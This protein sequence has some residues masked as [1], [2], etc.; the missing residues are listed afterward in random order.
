MTCFL[1]IYTISDCITPSSPLLII[2]SSDKISSAT[3]MGGNRFQLVEHISW[4]A[5]M[6]ARCRWIVKIF[7]AP[8]VEL[9]NCLPLIR[10]PGGDG[11]PVM[12]HPSRLHVKTNK[13][14]KHK[15]QLCLL[16][17]S[18]LNKVKDTWTIH[19]SVRL[20]YRSNSDT[21]TSKL[22]DMGNQLIRDFKVMIWTCDSI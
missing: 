10:I 4:K 11:N 21:E 12:I 7:N 5:A 8:Q 2:I 15:K 6:L 14:Y 22:E 13:I 17:L 18:C 9:A 20:R 3:N 19:K 16:G 1:S